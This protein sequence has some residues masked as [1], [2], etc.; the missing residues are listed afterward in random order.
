MNYATWRLNFTDPDYGTGPE[1]LI[2]AQGFSAEG[3]WV[4]GQVENGG[5]I[6]GYVTGEPDA[7]VL[8]AWEYTSI[9]QE[10]ALEFAQ[11]IN[12]EAYLLEDGRITAPFDET[13]L[14]PNTP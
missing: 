14:L 1:E 11:A 2:A 4:N 10:Q 7:S 3:S 8:T 6:L 9:T 13:I 5:T 12:P